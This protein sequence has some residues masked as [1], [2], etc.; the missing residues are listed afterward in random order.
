MISA[1]PL[2]SSPTLQQL[3]EDFFLDG[4]ILGV[5][6][7]VYNILGQTVAELVSNWREPG[8]HSVIWD[9]RDD[10]GQ[11]VASGIYFCKLT[12]NGRSE[13]KRIMMLK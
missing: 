5:T 7:V 1:T 3:R 11:P 12:S 2:I 6:M 9:G 8:E 10:G 4:S 13:V